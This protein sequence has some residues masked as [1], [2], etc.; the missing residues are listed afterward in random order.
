MPNLR[1]KCAQVLQTILENKVFF[2]ELKDNF[3]K[4]ELP[5]ANMLI[6]T[7]L[8][9]WA[10]LKNVLRFFLKKKIPH[11]HRPAEYLLLMAIAELLLMDTAQYAVINDTV[12]NVRKV[13]DKFLSGLANAV[14]RKIAAEKSIWQQ[15][16]QQSCYLPTDFLQLLRGYSDMQIEQINRS[17]NNI[18]PLDITVKDNPDV[19]AEKLNAEIL[20]NGSL[21][22]SGNTKITYLEGF[23][24]G[25]WWIQDVAAS[26]PVLTLDSIKG[27]KVIDLCAAPGGK[28]A[29]LAT[30]GANVTALDVSAE[31]L[32]KLRS[33]LQRLKI[34]NVQTQVIDAIDFMQNSTE[35]YDV[36]LLDAPCSASGTFRR[37][38]EV[39]H[40]KN[41]EDV[42]KATTLQEKL[43]NV[44]ENIITVGGILVYSVCSIAQDEG[45]RQINNFLK[46]HPNFKI[47]PIK[48]ETISSYGTW[49]DKLITDKGWIRT[50]PFYH[51]ISGGMDSFFICKMQRII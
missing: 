6:L 22:L 34:N 49:D 28:T 21:R 36:V 3:S 9:N 26:L 51:K 11:K 46:M 1:I 45:E 5:F 31:R 13:S 39:L 30:G 23:S 7:S 8:R 47:V 33:N 37:H 14:L 19:W 38:P 24:D 27:K 41:S 12:Q 10:G 35:K 42:A 15:K 50:M 18:P 4:D 20:P 32:E 29:Q 44:C 43:L 48:T 25:K 16:L 2:A 40:I 17:V